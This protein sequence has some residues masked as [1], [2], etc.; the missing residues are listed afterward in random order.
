MVADGKTVGILHRGGRLYRLVPPAIP[1]NKRSITGP[2][3][4][5]RH[6]PA[7]LLL[8]HVVDPDEASPVS[9]DDAPRVIDEGVF[10]ST[11]RAPV[12][13]TR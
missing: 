7:A 9:D 8:L 12:I 1:R 3:V 2:L 10:T 13:L 4:D 11:A 5:A 6:S